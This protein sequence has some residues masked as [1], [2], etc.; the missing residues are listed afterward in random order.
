MARPTKFHIL[1]SSN[2]SG[3]WYLP[4]WN[5]FSG[6]IIEFNYKYH[7]FASKDHMQLLYMCYL[8][9]NLFKNCNDCFSLWFLKSE[10]KIFAINQ[11]IW[12]N[13]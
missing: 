6:M 4:V 1:F 11:A 5:S 9:N 13:Y 12:N 8:P 3:G 2:K 10:R 7:G